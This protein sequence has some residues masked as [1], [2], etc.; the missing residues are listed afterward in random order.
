[1]GS[2]VVVTRAASFHI[3]GSPFLRYRRFSRKAGNKPTIL[4]P[5][6]HLLSPMISAVPMPLLRCADVQD[7]LRSHPAGVFV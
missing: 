4:E 1:M 5:L 7:Q 3:H 6:G 2:L